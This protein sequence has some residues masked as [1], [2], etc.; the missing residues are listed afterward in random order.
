M[1]HNYDKILADVT[2][3]NK[4]FNQYQNKTKYQDMT[5]QDFTKEMEKDHPTLYSSMNF[6]FN[7][8]VTGDLDPNVFS[9]MIKK[10]KEVQS[11]KTSNYDA[12]KDVGQKL[13]DTFIKPN[14]KK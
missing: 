11:N 14:L 1:S 9:Y 2:S 5:H 7:R 6:I 13:V 8:A 4:K 12:S 10:A 3:I